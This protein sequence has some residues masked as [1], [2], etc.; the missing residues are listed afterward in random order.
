MRL[1]L[2]DYDILDGFWVALPNEDF[3][4]KWAALAGPQKI[5][6]QVISTREMFEEETERF[7][8]QQSSD[9]VMFDERVEGLNMTICQFATQCDTSKTAEISI[10][11][12]KLWKQINETMDLGRLLNKRQSLFENPPIDLSPMVQLLESFTPYKVLWVTGADFN[13]WEDA[14]MGNPLPNVAPDTIRTM[15]AEFME[16]NDSCI[17]TFVDLPKVQ[18]VAY[19][20]QQRMNEFMPKVDVLEWVKNPAWILIHWQELCK[21]TEMEIKVSLSM[22]MEYLLAKGIMKFYD[23]VRQIS[24][25]ATENHHILEAEEREAERLRLEEEAELLARK[26]RRRGRKLT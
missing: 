14:W 24:E 5:Q 17:A 19:Y 25:S 15:M 4:V 21:T 9:L 10:E 13:K 3:K 2:F 6:K 18:S 1:K 23:V 7:V 26:N 20:F 16:A 11:I 8:K 12:K 22:S